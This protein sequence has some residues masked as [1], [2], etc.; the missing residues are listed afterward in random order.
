MVS[1]RWRMHTFEEAGD[2]SLFR[3]AQAL[4]DRA[5][6]RSPYGRE[7]DDAAI[8][9][10]IARQ[11]EAT[12]LSQAQY[13]VELEKSSACGGVPTCQPALDTFAIVSLRGLAAD[14]QPVALHFR[15]RTLPLELLGVYDPE[16]GSTTSIDLWRDPDT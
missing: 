13:G 8:R 4:D 9:G 16:T 3:A 12:A 2:G 11:P 7:A 14:G 5:V 6:E 10:V 1:V 15:V